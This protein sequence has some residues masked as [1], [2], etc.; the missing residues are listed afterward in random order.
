MWLSMNKLGVIS[1]VLVLISLNG[2]GGGN[3]TSNTNPIPTPSQGI[4]GAWE[5]VAK[6]T[7]TGSETLIEADI[8]ANGSKSSASGPSQVQ[9]ATHS[10]GIWYVNGICPS[11]SPGQNSLSGTVS[12]SSITFTFN[13]GGNTFT[14]QG[15]L[16]GTSIS[17]NYSGS[18]ASC[19]DS[20]TFTATQVPN[21]AGTFSGILT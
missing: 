5:F 20:G 6:S 8:S 2:C 17:G 10:N 9:V 14:G 21:L 7:G 12:G 3:T 4:S 15:T 19:S 16:S 13:E 18:S 1:I 11:P